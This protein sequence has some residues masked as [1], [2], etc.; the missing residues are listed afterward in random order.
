MWAFARRGRIHT[1]QPKTRA[2]LR[3]LGSYIH[4]QIHQRIHSAE[5][6]M[7]CPLGST[8]DTGLPERAS[9]TP[10]PPW[11]AEDHLSPAGAEP[12]VRLPARVVVV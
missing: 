12:V 4:T 3:H 8:R 5:P 6:L 11:A 9:D 7:R 10:G 1:G 2:L